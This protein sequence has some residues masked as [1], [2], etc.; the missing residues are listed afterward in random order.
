MTI[1][2]VEE[3]E[4]EDFLRLMCRIFNLDFDRAK[5]IFFRE[6]FYELRRKWAVFLRGEMIA[7]LTT[8]P[9]EFGDGNAAGIAGVGVDPSHRGK[10]IASEMLHHVTQKGEEKRLLLF[11]E[12]PRLYHKVGFQILDY[13]ISHPLPINPTNHPPK[14]ANFKDVCA[15]YQT[16]AESKPNRLRR[17][18]KRW[19]LWTW[20]MKS[21]FLLNEEKKHPMPSHTAE[22]K[23]YL[24]AT[25]ENSRIHY[26][27]LDGERVREILPEFHPLPINEPTEW[28]GLES[29]AHLLKI[30]LSSPKRELLLMGFGFSEPPQMFMSDQF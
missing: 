12:N 10:G 20:Q 30:P 19:E 4:A 7:C 27:C 2:T 13:V 16:W 9:L 14:R 17:N 15:T 3:H 1:R 26:F 25:E 24:H 6:P 21:C 18:S 5:G 22:R 11:A 29:M 23:N 28:Y 8:V